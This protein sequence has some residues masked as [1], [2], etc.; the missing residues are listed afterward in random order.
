ME[1]CIPESSIVL[2]GEFV[3]NVQRGIASC[4]RDFHGVDINDDVGDA[5]DKSVDL[6]FW[7]Y[8][9]I[10]FRSRERVDA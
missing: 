5:I 3:V 7:R 2:L 6:R 1:K 10:H 8:G 9:E 4:G